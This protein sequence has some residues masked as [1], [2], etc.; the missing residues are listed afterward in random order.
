MT[1]AMTGV[2]RA[3]QGNGFEFVR[4]DNIVV[5][6]VQHFPAEVGKIVLDTMQIRS[7]LHYR[8]T[9]RQLLQDGVIQSRITDEASKINFQM[10]RIQ[11][12]M[13]GAF[14]SWI[15]KLHIIDDEG[16]DWNRIKGRV[17]LCENLQELQ[18]SFL[19]I[20]A[21]VVSVCPQL[22]KLVH[23]SVQGTPIQFKTFQ[24]IISGCPDLIELDVAT[25]RFS[26]SFPPIFSE[27][28]RLPQLRKIKLPLEVFRSEVI[29]KATVPN[30]QEIHF[31]EAVK[32]SLADGRILEKLHAFNP[33]MQ[34]FDISVE[35]TEAINEILS[36]PLLQFYSM[37]VTRL[38]FKCE[39]D[40]NLISQLGSAF[41]MVRELN[42]HKPCRK[43]ILPS[44]FRFWKSLHTFFIEYQRG[45]DINFSITN[46]EFAYLIN[47]FKLKSIGLSNTGATGE[48]ILNLHEKCPELQKL[49]L[50]GTHANDEIV[51]VLISKCTQLKEIDLSQT[52][53]TDVIGGVLSES[54]PNWEIVR[55]ADTQL[56]DT[57]FNKLVSYG[58][59]F[60]CI[61]IS[62]TRVTYQ[63]KQHY[64]FLAGYT[65]KFEVIDNSPF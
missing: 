52:D 14:H 26:Q 30:L 44:V 16:T 21:G 19:P 41:P 39:V 53:V 1:S 12:L 6:L 27:L 63:V 59:N 46:L 49:S 5:G 33:Q 24:D 56:G 51:K 31:G 23:S 50:A 13:L 10:T 64:R 17:T 15:N 8:I 18:A 11:F 55:L 38:D 48:G 37:K 35:V 60:R 28:K 7:V 58:G 36:H 29:Q 54:C 3:D 32:W 61:D 47:H 20:F 22:K 40:D 9:C 62:H 4:R 42:F 2:K 25:V 43:E 34:T 65:K 45:A 57:G